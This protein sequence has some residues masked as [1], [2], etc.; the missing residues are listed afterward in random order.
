MKKTTLNYDVLPLSWIDQPR[1]PISHFHP[2]YNQETLVHDNSQSQ[3]YNN[4]FQD[5][6]SGLDLGGAFEVSHR[7]A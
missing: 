2:S 5:D 1:N 6:C 3:V 4:I 7:S